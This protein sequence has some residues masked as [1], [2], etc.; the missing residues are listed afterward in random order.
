MTT[1]S[2]LLYAFIGVG[3]M[4]I[5]AVQISDTTAVR[6]KLLSF[7]QRKILG[8][9]EASG[10]RSTLWRISAFSFIVSKLLSVKGLLGF[11]SRQSSSWEN[12]V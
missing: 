12:S 9:M 6:R 1:V 2:Q 3:K 11:W 7:N 4:H 8:P 10:F 5:S